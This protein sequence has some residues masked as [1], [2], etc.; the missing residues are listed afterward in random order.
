MLRGREVHF[1]VGRKFSAGHGV[2][3]F[4]KKLATYPREIN[5]DR[6]LTN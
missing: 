5:R 3:F 4:G 6:K 2:H 1:F